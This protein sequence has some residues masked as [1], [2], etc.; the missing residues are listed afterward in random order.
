MKTPFR[1][2]FANFRASKTFFLKNPSGSLL[3][4]RISEKTTQQTPRNLVLDVRTD[5]QIETWPSI[6]S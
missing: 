1:A 5:P 3:L 6:N 2:L 4:Y